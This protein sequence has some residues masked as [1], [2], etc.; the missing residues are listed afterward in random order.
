MDVVLGLIVKRFALQ[1]FEIHLRL[2]RI[3]S[4]VHVPARIAEVLHNHLVYLLQRNVELLLAHHR[5][6]G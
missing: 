2:E 5:K 6:I 3:H 4:V 1:P